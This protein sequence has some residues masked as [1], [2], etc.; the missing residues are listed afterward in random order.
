[1][2]AITTLVAPS[3]ECFE[4]KAGMVNLQCKNCVILIHT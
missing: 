4:I 2:A 3:G 1:M